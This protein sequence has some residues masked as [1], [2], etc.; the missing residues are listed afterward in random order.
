MEDRIKGPW[1]LLFK[2]AIPYKG[3]YIK[4]IILAI[5]G[6]ASG[7]VPYF[8]MADIIIKLIEGERQTSFYVGWCGICAIAYLL[9][10]IFASRSTMASHKV[11]FAVLSEIRKSITAKLAKVPM[12]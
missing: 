12:G 2:F 3:G 11:T 10:V 7:F 4:S 6:V 9:K 8:A 1:R 5:L